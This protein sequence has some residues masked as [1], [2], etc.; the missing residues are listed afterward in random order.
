MFADLPPVKGHNVQM[1]QAPRP[2]VIPLA[3][4]T[5]EVGRSE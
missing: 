1:E 5:E 2:T 4:V 3:L